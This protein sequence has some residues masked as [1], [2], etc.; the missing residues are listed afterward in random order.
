MTLLSPLIFF[1]L[2]LEICLKIS[3]ASET[4]GVLFGKVILENDALSSPVSTQN[5]NTLNS[6]TVVYLTGFDEPA[7]KEVISLTQKNKIFIPDVLAITQGQTI[8]ILNQDQIRH[9]VFSVSMARSFDL[10]I[11]PPEESHQVKFPK[12]GVVDVYCNI[13]PEMANTILVLPNRAFSLVGQDGFYRIKNVPVGEWTV[14]AWHPL[15]KPE[16]KTIQI[17][18]NKETQVNWTIRLTQ[19][20]VP[21]LN[22]HG[23]PYENRK[24]Y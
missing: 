4:H 24:K 5:P 17:L 18:S 6:K 12:P 1:G 22:K 9:N 20:P 13:H 11:T 10:G 23:R 3:A 15:G 14:Y 21:H 2:F 19:Q 7:P 8:E 16:H